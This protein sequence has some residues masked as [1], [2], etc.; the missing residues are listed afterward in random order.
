MWL[1]HRSASSRLLGA[2]E[3]SGTG[4][5]GRLGRGALVAC[6]LL[7]LLSTAFRLPARACSGSHGETPLPR[8]EALKSSRIPISLETGI[9]AL[10]F[11]ISTSSEEARGFFNQGLA[12]LYSYDWW[13]AAR[14]FRQVLEHHPGHP[15]AH[16]GLATAFHYLALPEL[17]RE[18]F[19]RARQR[20]G[21]VEISET[22][23]LWIQLHGE[24]LEAQKSRGEEGHRQLE[25]VRRKVDAWLQKRPKDPFVWLLRGL[26]EET[27]AANLGQEGDER[28]L[29]FYGEALRL[30]PDLAAAHHFLAHSFENLGRYEEAEAHAR[31]Y[32]ELAPKVPHAHHMHGHILPALGRWPEAEEAFEA[33][34]R[35]HLETTERSGLSPYLDWHFAHN[36]RFLALVTAYLGNSKAAEAHA[37]SLLALPLHDRRGAIYCTPLVEILMVAERFAEAKQAALKCSRGPGK[38]RPAVGLALA[39]EAALRLDELGEATRFLE[40]SEEALKDLWNPRPPSSSAEA[41]PH[42]LVGF[43]TQQ[44]IRFTRAQLALR[45]DP[46]SRHLADLERFAALWIGDTR[47]DGWGQAVLLRLPRL[48]TFAESQGQPALADRIHQLYTSKTAGAS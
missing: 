11:V 22:E 30:S 17:A 7:P 36:R 37:R 43:L 24:R 42:P 21:G 14:S 16:W 35:L 15:M 25:E 28:S 27:S 13:R 31:R 32:R 19:S 6:L 48:R 40:A 41:P 12:H 20:T 2:R 33:A 45:N 44:L 5:V 10:H 4:R 8:E 18:E 29:P 39:A 47:F 46:S 34:D 26:A 1:K 38:G 3:G 9:G 23:D